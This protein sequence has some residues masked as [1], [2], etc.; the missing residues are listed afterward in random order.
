[1]SGPSAIVA[2]AEYVHAIT[3]R[4]SDRSYREAFQRVALRLVPPGKLLFDFGSG[5]GIDARCYAEQ[6]RQVAAYDIDPRMNEYFIRHCS[7]W[8]AAG[9]VRLQGGGYREFLAAAPP[10][11][12]ACAELVTANFAPLN[13]IE[14]LPELFEKFATLTSPG[15][16]V[17]ASVL[18]PYF[19]GDLRYPWWWRNLGRLLVE[20]RYAVPGA[21]ALIWRRRLSDY[22]RACAP[23]FR[24]SEVFPGTDAAACAGAGWLRLGS[25]RFMFLLFR[26][27]DRRH[28]GTSGNGQALTLSSS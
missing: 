22:A 9:R 15:G 28:A 10:G 26:K 20:A 18:N 12:E 16:A 3:A 19:A 21:Q 14:D 17:L 4:A 27:P 23:H 13:L 2:G 1:M 25:C 24:L 6:G 5:P 7:E 11:S 8:L